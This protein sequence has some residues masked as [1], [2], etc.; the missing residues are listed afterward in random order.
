MIETI[1]SLFRN[2]GV[3]TPS[4]YARAMYKNTE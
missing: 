1:N 2:F 4:Q 3:E